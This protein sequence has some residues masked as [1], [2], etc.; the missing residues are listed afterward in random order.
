MDVR[1]TPESP[2]ELANWARARHPRID[3]R[4]IDEQVPADLAKHVHKVFDRTLERLIDLPILELKC[5][6]YYA[7]GWIRVSWDG[8]SCE[9]STSDD[10][11]ALE[12]AAA[13]AAHAVADSRTDWA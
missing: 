6:L 5:R 7:P 11:A 12:E 13:T 1:S 2:D 8:G 4:P 10:L 9:L 3:Y